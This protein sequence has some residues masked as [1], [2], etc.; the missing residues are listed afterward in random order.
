MTRKGGAQLEP[1]ASTLQDDAAWLRA[2]LQLPDVLVGGLDVAGRIVFLNDAAVRALE[3]PARETVGQRAVDLFPDLEGTIAEHIDRALAGESATHDARLWLR[4]KE[5]VFRVRYEPVKG[6]DGPVG[7]RVTSLEVTALLT[8][9]ERM[10]RGESDDHPLGMSAGAQLAVILETLPV[11]VGTFGRD[12]LVKYYNYLPPDWTDEEARRT[13]F[14]MMVA[15]ADRPRV[16]DVLDRVF[17]G[18]PRVDA[19]FEGVRH[20]HWDG[21]FVP[22]ALD[23]GAVTE[24]LAILHDVTELRAEEQRRQQLEEKLH[25]SARLESL[26]ALAGGL[27]HDF[28][29]I[30][31]RVLGNVH[32]ARD[33]LSGE[34]MAETLVEVQDDIMDAAHLCQQLLAYAGQGQFALRTTDLTDVVGDMQSLLGM[35]VKHRGSLFITAGPGQPW[36][37]TDTNQ[38][39]QL[40]VNL[41]TN[42][43]EALRGNAG[44]IRVETGVLTLDESGLEAY[45]AHEGLGAGPVA[46]VRV[47]DN[48]MG[49][50]PRVRRHV[51]E[52]FFTT[53]SEGRGLGLPACLGIVRGLGGGIL[54]E[55]HRG[56]GTE[57]TC[58][59]P[60]AERPAASWPPRGL[61][62]DPGGPP[63]A[64]FRVLV[65]DDEARMRR[66]IARALR[67]VGMEVTEAP[68][69][70][71]ALRLA[72]RDRF[73]VA[74]VDLTM[75]G[76]DG[77]RTIEALRDVQPHL[78]A[79]LMSGYARGVLELDEATAPTRFLAKPF[80][81]DALIDA[82][83]QVTTPA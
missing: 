73:D 19:S 50:E 76:L 5:R 82:L 26:G 55:S 57:V 25:A 80:T 7:V 38:M 70:T 66:V 33:A 59:F 45:M 3:L 23:E 24:V 44:G 74:L 51:F 42:A 48:G 32:A 16:Q 15:A 10:T 54:L 21:S 35:A 81:P 9:G 43:A 65:V 34:E 64:T 67:R 75:P 58:V 78:P 2:L 1:R 56:E 53:K 14:P 60:L 12:G 17:A 6:P 29:N 20:R 52:P 4:D 27:A 40:L 61:A 11:I 46:Y 71:E 28:N 41:V 62:V 47:A 36:V 22:F 79:V 77:T 39:R 30:F 68:D 18:E 63:P 8:A 13:P 31:A 37:K 72:R 83:Q 69:G 49:I